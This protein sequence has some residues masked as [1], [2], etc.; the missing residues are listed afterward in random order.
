MKLSV[1][2]WNDIMNEKALGQFKIQYLQSEVEK[3]DKNHV[4][5]TSAPINTTILL[6]QRHGQPT[7][8]VQ[9][10]DIHMDRVYFIHHFL[11]DEKDNIEG[12]IVILKTITRENICKEVPQDIWPLRCG[13]TFLFVTGQI[14]A[15]NNIIIDNIPDFANNIKIIDDIIL[16]LKRFDCLYE[17]EHIPKLHIDSLRRKYITLLGLVYMSKCNNKQS[18]VD[19]IVLRYKS[20]NLYTCILRWRNG[21]VIDYYNLSES[22]HYINHILPYDTPQTLIHDSW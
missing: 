20:L 2:K 13:K 10:E 11:E 8:V 21:K 9:H 19:E 18:I 16:N 14:N 12:D 6:F 4:Y 5:L 22:D 7:V 17:D 3:Y 1:F 15:M